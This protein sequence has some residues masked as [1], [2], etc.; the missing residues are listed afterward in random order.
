MSKRAERLGRFLEDDLGWYVFEV[1][2]RCKKCG[3]RSSFSDNYC[4]HCGGKMVADREEPKEIVDQ[5][6]EAIA[7]ALGEVITCKHS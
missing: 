3:H 6:E 2:Y 7:Y 5:L 4:A 1:S